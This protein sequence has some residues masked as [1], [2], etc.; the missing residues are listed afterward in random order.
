MRFKYT[1]SFAAEEMDEGVLR[2]AFDRLGASEFKFIRS[3]ED[4]SESSLS[5]DSKAVMSILADD[6]PHWRRDVV[7]A[8]CAN[9]FSY[10]GVN[11]AMVR[12]TNAGQIVCFKHGLYGSVRTDPETA[13]AF[14]AGRLFGVWKAWSISVSICG[15]PSCSPSSQRQHR[16]LPLTRARSGAP[17]EEDRLGIFTRR[18]PTFPLV[19][20]AGAI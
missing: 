2:D 20:R 10:A 13:T 11:K 19:E 4:Q 5:R 12:L 16:V 6:K 9:G 14:G 1:I 17:G 7:E 3:R 15:R 8:A 18:A